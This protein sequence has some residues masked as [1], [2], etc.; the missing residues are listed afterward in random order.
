MQGNW[1]RSTHGIKWS[2]S[3]IELYHNQDVLICDRVK[4]V[5][6]FYEKVKMFEHLGA[7]LKD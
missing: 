6:N 1:S 4:I 7:I 2:I 5:H 3:L